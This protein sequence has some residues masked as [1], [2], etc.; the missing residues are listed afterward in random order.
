[1]E[2]KYK[3]VMTSF[4][5]STISLIMNNID[6]KLIRAIEKN[7]R[8]KCIKTLIERGANVNLLNIHGHTPLV[9]AVRNNDIGIVEL[10]IDHGADVNKVLEHPLEEEAISTYKW[11]ALHESVFQTSTYYG[12]QRRI[13]LDIIQLLIDNHANINAK[14]SDGFT[15]L[16]YACMQNGSGAG[17][18]LIRAKADVNIV[19]EVKYTALMFAVY[20]E[21]N[22]YLIKDLIEAGAD[23][24]AKN[25]DGESVMDIVKKYQRRLEFYNNKIAFDN[26]SIVEIIE[27]EIK[28]RSVHTSNVNRICIHFKLP[29][30]VDKIIRSFLR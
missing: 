11:S 3:E 18:L 12:Y 2:N 24:Y 13:N 17:R 4:N 6:Y 22:T 14:S 29:N 9:L 30:G 21:S 8:L 7:K 5:N 23:V 1:M 19:D 15:P 27:E 10:L 26:Y 28:Q 25:K 20:C 16:M